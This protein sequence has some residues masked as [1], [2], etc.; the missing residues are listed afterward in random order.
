MTTK[1]RQWGNSYGLTVTKD[2]AKK[3]HLRHGSELNVEI[4]DG[5]YVYRPIQK[6]PQIPTLAEMIASIPKGGVKLEF[7]SVDVGNEIVLWE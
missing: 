6:Q 5:A 7:D 3:L 4:L 2:A 1:L